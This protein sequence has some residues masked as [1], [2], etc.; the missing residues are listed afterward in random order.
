M[1]WTMLTLLGCAALLV[2]VGLGWHA[3]GLM[4]SKNAA[5]VVLRNVIDLSVAC[6]AFWAIGAAVLHRN[7]GM[8]FDAKHLQGEATFVHLVL[9]L[10]GVA[11]VAGALAERS[12]FFPLLAAPAVLAGI[13]IPICGHWVWDDAGWLRRMGFWD[14]G[15]ASVLHVVGGIFA[16]AGAVIVGPRQGKYNT[17]RSANFIPGHSVPMASLGVMLMLA[18]WLPYLMAA[19]ALHGGAGGSPPLKALIAASAGAIVAVLVSNARYGKPDIMLTYSGLLGALVSISAAGGAISGIGALAIGAVAGLVVP[20]MTVILD[21]I[22]KID[23]PAGGIAV[24]AIGGAWGVIAIGLFIPAAS[25]GEKLKLIGV[26]ILGLIVIAIVAAAFAVGLYL[27]LKATVGLRLHEDAEYDGA[28]LA[29]HDIN[30]YP[31][32]QQ[33]MIK[34]YHLREA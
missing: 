27:L 30:A 17:D 3:A 34:S 29:E 26:Q 24:H 8:L 28:D 31:D 22:I 2:R 7:A 21:L 9:V 5:G 23:D 18:G 25:A 15:G 14:V 19:G 4:R 1:D 16:A 20:I 6:L 33:T 10:I 12:R 32:F 13:V 11:P